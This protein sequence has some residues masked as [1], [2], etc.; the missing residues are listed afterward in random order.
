MAFA[1]YKKNQGKYTR[2][3][4]ALVVVAI[5]GIGCYRLYSKLHANDAGLWIETMVPTVVFV[6][7]SILAFWLVNKPTVADFLIAAESEMKKVSWSSRKEIAV[8]TF[9]VIMVVVI[10]STLIGVTD[11]VFQMFFS[12]LFM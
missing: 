3:Y 7:L 1:I 12:W 11:L 8:S 4:S 6:G 5:V 9:V 2:L 10:M